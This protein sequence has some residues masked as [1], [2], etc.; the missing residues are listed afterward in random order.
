MDAHCVYDLSGKRLD[1]KAAMIDS[2]LRSGTP[3]QGYGKYRM[4]AKIKAPN[5]EILTT[6]Y[7]NFGPT[8]R[9]LTVPELDVIGVLNKL[10]GSAEANSNTGER[11]RA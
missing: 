6:N 1:I 2:G 5:E 7:G 4:H 10:H 8:S 9:T 11:N 3:R